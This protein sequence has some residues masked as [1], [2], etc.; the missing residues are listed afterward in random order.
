MVK[1][2]PEFSR[3]NLSKREIEILS[4][5]YESLSSDARQISK[6]ISISEQKIYPYLKN[7]VERGFLTSESTYPAI[8]KI[9]HPNAFKTELDKAKLEIEQTKYFLRNL[10]E[11]Q[12]KLYGRENPFFDIATKLNQNIKL[13]LNV[14]DMANTEFLQV[15]NIYHRH[16]E[17]RKQKNLF[18]KGIIRMINRGVVY[19]TIY[20]LNK[21]IPELLKDYTKKFE[22][23]RLDTTFQR[24]DVIDKRF[25]LIKIL[26]E[27]DILNFIG[28]IFIDD[29]NLAM[30]L[31]Y[32]FF[33]LWN[34]A[35]KQ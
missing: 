12:T 19:K 1:I 24:C 17:N 26:D 10:A 3:F 31:R 21:P 16:S 15:L 30:N 35:A 18:E 32:T 23:K 27:H 33:Q 29:E 25:V 2:I 4:Y 22:I 34:K 11:R 13:Q 6:A 8:Y 5:L 7:L 9:A 28:S 20:P 14:F